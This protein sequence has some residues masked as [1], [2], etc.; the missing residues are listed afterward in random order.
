MGNA[1]LVKAFYLRVA[2]WNSEPVDMGGYSDFNIL[3]AGSPAAVAGI[4]HARG[5]NADVPPQWLIYI[6]VA[7]LD[8][9]L[10]LCR[11]LN[12]EVL[13]PIR[14]SGEGALANIRDPAGAVCVLFQVDGYVP[15]G[16][17]EFTKA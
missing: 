6:T 10:K 3:P 11:E 1:E 2:G 8:T 17:A 5:L 9:S 4:C 13:M 14:P 15:Q 16:S 12:G 7:D